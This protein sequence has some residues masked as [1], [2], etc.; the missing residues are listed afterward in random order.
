DPSVPFQDADKDGFTN[1]DEFRAG[2]DPNNK[3]DHPPYYSKLFLAKF[4]KVPLRLVLNAYDGAPKRDKPD[5][6]S[7][8]IDTIDLKQPSEFLKL[9][10]M[11]PN[12]KFKLE[13]FEYK[14][15]FNPKTEDQEEVSELT[16]IATDTGDK[17]VLI[18]N[19]VTDSPDVLA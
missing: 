13:K 1:E 5:K 6:F 12:T 19:K 8:Q 16:L 9:G 14:T 11:V 4:I 10:E 3:D 18:Y 7:F 15:A 17:I 2:T